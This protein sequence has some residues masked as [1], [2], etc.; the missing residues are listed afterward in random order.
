[1]TAKEFASGAGRRGNRVYARLLMLA[2]LSLE[3][4]LGAGGAQQPVYIFKSQVVQ[5]RK[6]DA[7]MDNEINE[8]FKAFE[9]LLAVSKSAGAPNS[10]WRVREASWRRAQEAWDKASASLPTPVQ[11]LNR[12]AIPLNT[13]RR[14][15]EQADDLFLHARDNPDPM[16]AVEL[17]DQHKKLLKQAKG[18]LKRAERCFRATRNAFLKGTS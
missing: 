18:P 10:H 13:A 14:L 16:K 1:M 7:A 4:M 11:G 12:C 5:T 9:E 15:I 2:G 6:A 3:L 17:L 8:V